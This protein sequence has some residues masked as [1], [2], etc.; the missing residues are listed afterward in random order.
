MKRMLC[1]YFII[2][3]FPGFSTFFKFVLHSQCLMFALPIAIRFN[4]RPLYVFFLQAMLIAM[5]QP[6]PLVADLVLYL[7]LLPL[8]VLHCRRAQAGLWWG[9]LMLLAAIVGP[10]THYQWIHTRS[11]NANFYYAATLVWGGAQVALM[12]LLMQAMIDCDRE[13]QGKPLRFTLHTE[14]ASVEK[15]HN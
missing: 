15:K 2:E 9:L 5:M 1:R 4:H 6:Y 14:E 10:L 13:L 3:M 8:F 12:L 7:S 11:A